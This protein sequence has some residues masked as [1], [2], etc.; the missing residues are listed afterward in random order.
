MAHRQER[1]LMHIVLKI[2][3][4]CDRGALLCWL[5]RL[6]VLESVLDL[7]EPAH[8]VMTEH[9]TFRVGSRATSVE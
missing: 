1:D 2:V 3:D 6:L 9:D 4:E 5:L 8:V 7:P